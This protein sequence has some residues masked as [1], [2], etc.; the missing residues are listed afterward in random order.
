MQFQFSLREKFKREQIEFPFYLYEP[1]YESLY[2]VLTPHWHDELE[3]WYCLCDG[4]CMLDGNVFLFQKGD[5]VIINK[6][7]IHEFEINSPDKIVIFLFDYQFLSFAI[8]DE[9]QL[10]FINPLKYEQLQLTPFIHTVHPMYESIKEIL[11]QIIKLHKEKSIAYELQLKSKLYTLLYYFYNY[12]EYK[13]VTDEATKKKGRIQAIQKSIEYMEIN[14]Q[15]EITISK[16]AEISN[17][18]KFYYIRLFKELTNQTP[19][20]YL[21][22]LRLE[23]AKRLMENNSWN[24]TQ[25]SYE[26][27]FNRMGYFARKFKQKFGMTPTEYKKTLPIIFY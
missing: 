11:E 14:M 5:I 22:N 24:I 12:T 25:V 15:H 8:E 21:T 23:Y 2:R 7:V 3:I 26:V 9:C 13:I 1:R 20:E 16:L 18:S 4:K 10:K 19:M 17:V 27:G 6:R